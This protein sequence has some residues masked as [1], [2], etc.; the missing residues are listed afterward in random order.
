MG[1]LTIYV[2]EDTEH[3]IKTAAGSAGLSLSRWVAQVVRA[4][5]ETA[6]PA[7]VLEL[8]GAWPDFPDADEL[9][10]TQPLDHRREKL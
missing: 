5:P 7:E 6:W 8:A 3:R 4:K 9:R 10:A 1:Q 2:D